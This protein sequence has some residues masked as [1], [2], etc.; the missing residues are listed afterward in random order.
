M[1]CLFVRKW[2]CSCLCDRLVL[3]VSVDRIYKRHIHIT[4]SS[5]PIIHHIRQSESSDTESGAKE[6]A[7][8]IIVV[9]CRRL[10]LSFPPHV[11]LRH[12]PSRLLHSPDVSLNPT[13]ITTTTTIIFLLFSLPLHTSVVRP[14]AQP[15]AATTDPFCPSDPFPPPPPPAD[16][17]TSPVPLSANPHRGHSSSLPLLSQATKRG[18]PKFTA[19]LAFQER[20]GWLDTHA[21]THGT[22]DPT[23]WW[24]RH[25]SHPSHSPTLHTTLGV[26]KSDSRLL[27]PLVLLRARHYTPSPSNA[28]SHSEAVVLAGRHTLLLLLLLL[29]RLYGD[30]GLY[31]APFG[32]RSGSCRPVASASLR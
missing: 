6:E 26:T 30:L 3:W 19:T 32:S 23:C 12:S 22:H 18:R 4:P 25:A 31:S 5:S 16:E 11:Y 1:S 15:T 21:H 29:A 2:S 8:F 24:Q 27:P 13:P 17:P 9:G 14:L 7:I 20:R 10:G 28:G